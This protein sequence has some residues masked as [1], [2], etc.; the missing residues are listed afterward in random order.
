MGKYTNF[1]TMVTPRVIKLVWVIGSIVLIL[2]GVVMLL[3]G[4]SGAF[5]AGLLIITLGNLLW[6]VTSEVTILLFLIY[7]RL[8][9]I[10]DET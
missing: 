7:D 1:E 3:R 4:S 6:R 8:G 9:E 5:V 2:A 10:R